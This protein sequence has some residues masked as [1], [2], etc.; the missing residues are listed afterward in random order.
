MAAEAQQLTLKLE[1]GKPWGFRLLGG[2]D[3]RAPLQITRVRLVFV[4]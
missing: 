3:H 1:G 4:T 2:K